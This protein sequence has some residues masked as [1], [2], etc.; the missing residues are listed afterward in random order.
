VVG[1]V[2]AELTPIQSVSNYRDITPFALAAIALLVMNRHRVIT[3]WRQ[4]V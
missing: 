3:V 1:V 2:D 4:G